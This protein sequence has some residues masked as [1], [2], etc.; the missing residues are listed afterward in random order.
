MPA[1]NPKPVNRAALAIATLLFVAATA[2]AWAWF[3]VATPVREDSLEFQPRAQLPG[4][5]FKPMPIDERD[6]EVLANTNLLSGRFSSKDAGD[7]I[8]FFG[9]WRATSARQMNVV[10]HTPDICWV[11]GGWVAVDVGQ[12]SKIEIDFGGRKI[13]F[14]CR[15]F[16]AP[17]SDHV[18]LTVWCTLV[19][20]QLFEEG[21]RFEAEQDLKK[22][23]RTRQA[24]ANRR[25]GSEQFFR[26]L[27]ERIPGDG[28]KQFV[29][30]S[31]AVRNDTP[32][33]LERLKAF[34]QRWLELKVNRSQHP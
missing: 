28:S 18:E 25:R 7:F 33:A 4:T 23:V 8:V 11:G 20:G 21:E 3:N 30:F 15:A 10:Q 24:S 17:R 26:V 9:D 5:E 14:E 12:P 2:G 16:R 34:G 27:R 31:T 13:P 29:R 22:D 19:S 1:G 32:R 6:M